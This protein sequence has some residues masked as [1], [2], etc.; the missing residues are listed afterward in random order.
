MSLPTMQ[1]IE[2]IELFHGCRHAQVK[3]IDRLG[4]TLDV[5]AGRP[6]CT[7]GKPGSQFFVLL[8]GLVQVQNCSGRLALLHP[9]AWFGETALIHDT[10]QRASVTTIV[11]SVLIVFDRSE[12][13]ALRHLA[14]HVRERLDDTAARYLR[15]ETPT[16]HSWYQP[17]DTHAPLDQASHATSSQPVAP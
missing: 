16:S 3:E 2:G 8:D 9:G 6:L 12:F 1:R 5:A 7:E 11:E 15:G 17:I 10:Y 13:N 14:P 4:T